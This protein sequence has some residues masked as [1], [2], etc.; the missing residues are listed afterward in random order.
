MPHYLHVEASLS[1]AVDYNFRIFK[2]FLMSSLKFSD[3]EIFGDRG[4]T[5]EIHIYFYISFW[6]AKTEEMM[7]PVNKACHHLLL[8]G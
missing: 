2:T 1:N 8:G 6:L 7:L 5:F 3:E 4:L